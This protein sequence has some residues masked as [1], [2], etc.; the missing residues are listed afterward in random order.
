VALEDLD[1]VDGI[2]SGAIVLDG[3]AI[4][5]DSEDTEVLVDLADLDTIHSGL[6]HLDMI[7]S[8]VVDSEDLEVVDSDMVDLEDSAVME[9]LDMVDL[10]V[11]V[12]GTLIMLDIGIHTCQF[13]MVAV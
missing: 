3:L 12:D 13:I 2:L 7:L 10:A 8:G 5:E 9:D 4:M 6:A 11:G 1:T